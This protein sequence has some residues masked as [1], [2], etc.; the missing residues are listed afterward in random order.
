M[1]S[2]Q[3]V[4]DLDEAI[5]LAPGLAFAYFERGTAYHAV[6][7]FQHAIADY[8]EAI[9][10]DP[11]DPITF[12]NRGMALT[13]IDKLDQALADFDAALKLSPDNVNVF[14]HRAFAYALKRDYARAMADID[15]AVKLAPTSADRLL[16]SRADPGLP[17]RDRARHR[18]LR[19]SIR[20]DP[21]ESAR[22]RQPGHA[23]Q[24]AGRLHQGG[25]RSRRGDQAEAA[26]AAF[27]LNRG[28]AHFGLRQYDKA[29]ADYDEV[30]KLDLARSVPPTTTVACRAPRWARTIPRRS[31]TATRR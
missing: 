4:A 30:L 9:K 21:E 13:Y 27:Y 20:L 29:I 12:I 23:L 16:L 22:L 2:K 7:D 18:R 3:A 25:G 26:R 17:G 10:L 19:Q 5:K 31:P 28:V 8:T 14:I 24:R 1:I 6:D 15:E 11:K